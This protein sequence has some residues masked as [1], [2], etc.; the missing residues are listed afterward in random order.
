MYMYILLCKVHVHVQNSPVREL[1]CTCTY[2]VYTHE[3]RQYTI[4]HNFIDFSTEYM[5]MYM[6][7]VHVQCITCTVYMY[8]CIYL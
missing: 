4:T 2:V 6:Y 8:N 7:T 5:Y 3:S 1:Y